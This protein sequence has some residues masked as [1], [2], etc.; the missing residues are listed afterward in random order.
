MEVGYADS[1][2]EFM[3]MMGIASET[4]ENDFER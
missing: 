3:R 4:D 2:E 1:K